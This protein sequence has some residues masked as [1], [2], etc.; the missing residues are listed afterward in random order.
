MMVNHQEHP[1]TTDPAGR[2]PAPARTGF[3]ARLRSGGI[4]PDDSED[5]RL[6]K[7]LLLF[8]TGL[9]CTVMMVWVAI[10]YLLGANL[11]RDLA[12]AVQL[13]LIGNVLLYIRTRHFESFRTT[14]LGLFLFLPFVA[15]WAAGNLIDSS[16]II[17]WG[18][19]GPIGAIMCIGARESIG[20]FIAWFALTVISGGVDYYLGDPLL[21][22][23]AAVSV[24]MALVFLTLNILG[25]ATISYVLLH[26]FIEQKRQI[27]KR[28]EESREQVRIAQDAADHLFITP[29]V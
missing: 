1:R 21:A 27:E 14:Q 7:S 23:K 18:L 15:Q 10:Y 24:R 13:L 25:V 6:N 28:L 4:E 5:L 22:Q 17:L 26:Y 29:F 19:L 20:W 16:G 8:A 3:A 12:L 9:V 2:E 11:S